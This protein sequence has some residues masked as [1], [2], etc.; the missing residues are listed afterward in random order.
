M[1]HWSPDLVVA[2]R[3]FGS[4]PKLV[5]PSPSGN[6]EFD[7][8]KIKLANHIRDG[9][10]LQFIWKNPET[11]NM[12]WDEFTITQILKQASWELR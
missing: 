4:K 6:L 5:V 1:S 7:K 9:L 11:L 12:W 8:F 3:H 10:T 2:Y